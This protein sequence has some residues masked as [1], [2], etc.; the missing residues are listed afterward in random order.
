PNEIVSIG[1]SGQ[2]TLRLS[3]YA[4][5][6]PGASLEIG[7]FENMGLNDPNYPSGQAGSPATGFSIDSAVV[8]VSP[9]GLS[10]YSFG[11]VT[12]DVPANGYTDL[13]DPYS[14]APGSVLSDFQQ[15]FSGNLNSFDGLVYSDPSNFD[16]LD[17]LA[18]SG[19]G[20]W[21]D[22]SG[23]GFAQV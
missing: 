8:E 19:G 18:G 21:L 7:I 14:G 5:A 22:I 10:W 1:E 2:I 17:R 3:N 4:I 23:S 15:P 16:I 11:S 12:V 6:Q 20:K 9:D 13:T